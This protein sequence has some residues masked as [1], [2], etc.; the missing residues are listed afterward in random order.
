MWTVSLSG[1]ALWPWSRQPDPSLPPVAFSGVPTFEEA[2]AVI[3]ANSDRV[4]QLQTDEASIRA[5]GLPALQAN[6]AFQRPR[7]FRM[8]AELFQFTGREIDIGSNEELFWF[9]LQRNDPPA[10]FFARHD[11]YQQSPVRHL[12]PVEP[13]WL[14]DALGLVRLEPNL[15]HEGPIMVQ[16]DRFE[17]HTRIPAAQGELRRVLQVNAEYGWI[18]QQTLYDTQGRVI[19]AAS[20]ANHRFY[21]NEGVTLPHQ[22][23][24][25]MAPGQ[26]NELKFELVIRSYFVN[27]MYAAEGQLWSMP[28]DVGPV[29]DI[30]SGGTMPVRSP[31]P[32]PPPAYY[33]PQMGLR[34][35]PSYR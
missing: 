35:Y 29:V 18:E 20:A 17:I 27:R 34:G 21:P 26:P 32:T 6:L 4:Q 25:Q 15:V 11:V 24:I 10:V 30:T 1:C 22:I 13:H 19:A 31:A 8:T 3:N 7:N 12:L 28:Q 14:I 23:Q 5:E 33:Q 9:W 16:P 2:A